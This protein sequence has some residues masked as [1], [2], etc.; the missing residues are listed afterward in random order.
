MCHYLA[1]QCTIQDYGYETP[2]TFLTRYRYSI[3]NNDSAKSINDNNNRVIVRRRASTSVT[4][5]EVRLYL[6]YK[7]FIVR[8]NG[9]RKLTIYIYLSKI[10]EVL[11]FFCK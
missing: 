7:K 8:I 2:L 5:S 6:V 11:I 3:Y 4:I 1:L 10:R 9:Q